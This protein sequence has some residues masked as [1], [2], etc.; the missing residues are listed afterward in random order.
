MVSAAAEP[1]EVTSAMQWL[2]VSAMKISPDCQGRCLRRT[3]GHTAGRDD[4][5]CPSGVTLHHAAAAG[6][7]DIEIARAI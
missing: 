6:I 2:P 7:G 5:A 3:E 4:G 1:P